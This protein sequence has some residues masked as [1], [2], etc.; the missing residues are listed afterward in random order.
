MR[1]RF[2]SEK[3]IAQGIIQIIDTTP[4]AD[5]FDS[6]KIALLQPNNRP[7]AI[8]KEVLEGNRDKDP[9]ARLAEV[10]EALRA[11]YL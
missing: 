10:R 9:K 1:D 11:I 3:A 6:F 8:A 4:P 5:V 2:G 7:A